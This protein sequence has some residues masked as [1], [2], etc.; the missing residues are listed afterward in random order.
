[1][2]ETPILD[3]LQNFRRDIRAAV[4]ME[5]KVEL[6]NWLEEEIKAGRV[7]QT[8]AIDRIIKKVDG[9]K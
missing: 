9:L 8:Q 4:T 5:I 6:L 3:A 7:R 2:T 1:M